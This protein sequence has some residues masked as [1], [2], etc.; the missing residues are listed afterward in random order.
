MAGKWASNPGLTWES[1]PRTPLVFSAGLKEWVREPHKFRKIR[2][3]EKELLTP[4][5]L[6]FESSNTPPVTDESLIDSGS[7]I[8]AVAGP[9]FFLS[10]SH[11]LIA[12]P[13][14]LQVTGVDKIQTLPG[15]R[16]GAWVDVLMPV[17][18]RHGPEIFLFQH[19]FLYKMDTIGPRIFFGY[20]MLEPFQLVLVPGVPYL[21]PREVLRLSPAH[22]KSITPRYNSTCSICTPQRCLECRLM[23]FCSLHGSTEKPL[24][25]ILKKQGEEHK[26]D[27]CNDTQH[28][29]PKGCKVRFKV[30]KEHACNVNAVLS[31]PQSTPS[32][33]PCNTTVPNSPT[34]PSRLGTH[35]PYSFGD[36]VMFDML[37]P[38]PEQGFDLRMDKRVNN[39]VRIRCRPVHPKAELT[40][41]L[42]PV[43]KSPTGRDQG[44]FSRPQLKVKRLSEYA[45][46]PS[47]E[48]NGSVGADLVAAHDTVIQAK[49]RATVPT[50]LAVLA[51]EGYYAR[52][53][54]RSGLSK[55]GI[56]LGGG[57][58]DL[59]YRGNV[60]II[61]INSGNQDFIARRGDRIAQLIAEACCIPDIVEVD[62]LPTTARGASGFGSTG[63]TTRPL[64]HIKSTRHDRLCFLESRMRQKIKDSYHRDLQSI[65]FSLPPFLL[66]RVYHIHPIP[67][68]SITPHPLS[69]H[70]L[71]TF[72][73]HCATVF[74][75]YKN[76][77][78]QIL[79]P[80]QTFI[81]IFSW[82]VACVFVPFYYSLA[83]VVEQ[84]LLGAGSVALFCTPLPFDPTVGPGSASCRQVPQQKSPYLIPVEASGTVYQL[85]VRARLMA[86][87]L[88]DNPLYPEVAPQ[89]PVD[90]HPFIEQFLNIL[91]TFTH[92]SALSS[93]AEPS[94]LPGKGKGDRGLVRSLSWDSDSEAGSE[95]ISSEADTEDVSPSRTVL[96][97]HSP[98]FAPDY[99]MGGWGYNR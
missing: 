62:S 25:S 6:H 4:A 54:P 80:I 70:I 45:H 52:L 77:I 53:A 91:S 7:L 64:L 34:P 50:D 20:P 81:P 75:S 24:S 22:L 82:N 55:R 5:Q 17:W 51:P 11:C 90:N 79:N 12:A 46:L 73:Q 57:V 84:L 33:L 97:Q 96:S 14:P 95:A 47:R 9:E 72:H 21:V 98:P 85:S 18:G 89:S 35:D 32:L 56:D 29:N 16:E 93:P 69:T 3:S 43:F 23:Y 59:D 39:S 63:L 60:G 26:C 86:D 99:F 42:P 68:N 2:P 76:S 15:G 1:I 66:K 88:L 27:M 10:N 74:R 37:L 36:G 40:E 49:S 87:R 8:P 61:L 38:M 31:K 67:I 58:V 44:P 94:P 19:I 41:S 71:R 30:P 78:F 65:L 28:L 13:Q 92:H 48:R 83:K